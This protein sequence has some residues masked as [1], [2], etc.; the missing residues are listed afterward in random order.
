MPERR[1][2]CNLRWDSAGKLVEVEGNIGEKWKRGKVGGKGAGEV[3]GREAE[4]DDAAAG[5]AC[6]AGPGAVAG[7]G[8][9]GGERRTRV[10]GNGISEREKG[11]GFS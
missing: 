10:I 2:R 6:D 5:V 9:P 7:G 11:L 3:E 8:V 1:N 4:A